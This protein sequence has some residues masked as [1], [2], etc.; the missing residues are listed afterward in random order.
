HDLLQL[1]GSMALNNNTRLFARI[2]NLT[3]EKYAS[4]ADYA[5]GSY[6][7]FGGQPRVLHLGA[8]ISF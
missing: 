4:R 5:F 2:E 3:D 1:R 8:S 6:R 7:F